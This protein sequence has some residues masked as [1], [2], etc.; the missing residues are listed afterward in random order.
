LNKLTNIEVLYSLIGVNIRLDKLS[1][2]AMFTEH[3]TL[4]KRSTNDI[5]S[6]LDSSMLDRFC[7]EIL[8]RI[9]RQIKWL[10]LESLSMKCILL[11]ADYPNLYGLSLFNIDYE[12]VVRLCDGKKFHFD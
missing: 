9:N 4:M 6:S 5:I 2:D 1:S 11:A 12:T 7:S 3:L 10:N 8:P